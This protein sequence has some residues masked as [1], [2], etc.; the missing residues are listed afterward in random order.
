MFGVPCDNDPY[1]FG[2][3]RL[4]AQNIYTAAYPLHDVRCSISFYNYCLKQF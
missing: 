2:I 3:E 1:L 4:I